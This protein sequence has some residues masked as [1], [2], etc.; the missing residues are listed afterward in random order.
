MTIAAG[1]KLLRITAAAVDLLIRAITMRRRVQRVIA[2][3][4][5]EAATMIGLVK[6]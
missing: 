6:R 3:V 1:A 4:A 2:S 5:I